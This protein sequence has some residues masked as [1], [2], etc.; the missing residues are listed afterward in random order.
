[1]YGIFIRRLTEG[2]FPQHCVTC[3]YGSDHT[4]DPFAT[5]SPCRL[6]YV[7]GGGSR[8]ASRRIMPVEC[9]LRAYF[10]KKFL[11]VSQIIICLFDKRNASGMLPSA[12]IR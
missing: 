9:I 2:V 1:M 6:S 8:H 11:F 5:V 7:K 4:A 12:N 10:S 3:I